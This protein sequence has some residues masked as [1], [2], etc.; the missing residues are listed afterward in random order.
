[1]ETTRWPA[2][3]DSGRECVCWQVKGKQKYE[4]ISSPEARWEG[5]WCL[6]AV[7]AW[8]LRKVCGVPWAY[9]RPTKP[10]SALNL[11]Y[12]VYLPGKHPREPVSPASP[13]CQP[14]QPNLCAF[15]NTTYPYVLKISSSLVA[16]LVKKSPAMQETPVQ[17]L[18]WEDP[19]G[20]G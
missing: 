16:Q 11:S 3:Q 2:R 12:F 9:V 18:G 5:S 15:H 6:P 13:P 4:T 1:M 10:P 14:P 7:R 17:F 19:L 8:P 20:K